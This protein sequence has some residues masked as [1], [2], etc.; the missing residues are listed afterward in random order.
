MTVQEVPNPLVHKV[1]IGAEGGLKRARTKLED[2]LAQKEELAAQR[3][4][5]AELDKMAIE[6]ENE[7]SRM[8]GEPPVHKPKTDDDEDDKVEQRD[9]KKRQR[10]MNA[11]KALID[12]GADP[13]TVARMMLQIPGENHASAPQN[14]TSITD[15]TA[16]MKDLN[17]IVATQVAAR[18]SGKDGGSDDVVKELKQE[19]KELRGSITAMA[20]GNANKIDPLTAAKNQAVA[21]NEMSSAMLQYATSL[22]WAPPGKGGTGKLTDSIEEIKEKNRHDE[23][24]AELKQENDHKDKL[25]EIAASIPERIGEGAAKYYR[26]SSNTQDSGDGFEHIRCTDCGTDIV[27]T[28][29]TGD[30]VKCPKCGMVYARNNGQIPSSPKNDEPVVTPPPQ[31][32]QQIGSEDGRSDIV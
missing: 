15:L 5:A 26:S 32:P 12:S 13:N 31:S 18:T 7:A 2:I 4:S 17:D 29:K 27:I 11:A 25:V 1:T 24:M 21:M 14:G 23:K 8:R 6:A 10:I 28:P 19:I 20:S 16:A 30:R 3:Y 9:E 22:G